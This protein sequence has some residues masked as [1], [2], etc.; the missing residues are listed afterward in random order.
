MSETLCKKFK[1]SKYQ[2]KQKTKNLKCSFLTPVLLTFLLDIYPKMSPQVLGIC[3]KCLFMFKN[4]IIKDESWIVWQLGHNSHQPIA[5]ILFIRLRR[6][7][8]PKN[9]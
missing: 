1:I 6:F 5:V 7:L 4:S 3:C 9:M 8:I 2:S